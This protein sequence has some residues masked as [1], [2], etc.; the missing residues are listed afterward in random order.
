MTLR[1]PSTWVAHGGALLMLVAIAPWRWDGALK[2]LPA[3]Q[4]VVISLIGVLLVV[5]NW[6]IGGSWAMAISQLA[7]PPPRR[8]LSPTIWLKLGTAAIGTIASRLGG[9]VALGAVTG[10]GGA[11]WAALRWLT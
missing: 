8:G 11:I 9:L 4:T 6:L 2:L 3:S 10:I 7:V 5:L 1:D